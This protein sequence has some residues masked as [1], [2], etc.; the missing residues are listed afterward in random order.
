MTDEKQPPDLKV[1]TSDREAYEAKFVEELFMH[2][3]NNDMEGADAA[4][5]KIKPQGKGAISLVTKSKKD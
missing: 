3:D 2:L 5:E 1:I 4:I